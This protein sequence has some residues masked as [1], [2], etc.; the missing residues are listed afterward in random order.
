[1]IGRTTVHYLEVLSYLTRHSPEKE[2]PTNRHRVLQLPGR[3]ERWLESYLIHSSATL[4]LLWR[5]L[6]FRLGLRS[7]SLRRGRLLQPAVFYPGAPALRYYPNQQ[8]QQLSLD[9]SRHDHELAENAAPSI[10]PRN[11]CDQP[12]L[13]MQTFGPPRAHDHSLGYFRVV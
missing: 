3:E 9:K 6:R 12:L 4:L 5:M 1:M 2:T 13:S 11:A 8:Q 10:Y 7:P